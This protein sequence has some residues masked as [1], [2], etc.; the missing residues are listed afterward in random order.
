MARGIERHGAPVEGERLT[1]CKRLDCAV[2]APAMGHESARRRCRVRERVRGDVVAVRVADDGSRPRLTRVEPEPLL[3]KVDAAVPEDGEGD[4][5]GE[6]LSSGRAFEE[7]V[8][9]RTVGA[10][11]LTGRPCKN[12]RLAAGGAG[13]LLGIHGGLYSGDLEQ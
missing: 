9:K 2:G 8:A 4:Q 10:E 6:L 13:L 1:V 5:R 7:L 3:G 11:A 12:A